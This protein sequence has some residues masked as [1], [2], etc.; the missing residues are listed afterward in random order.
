MFIFKVS[1]RLK[2]FTL[3]EGKKN[4]SERLILCNKIYGTR[5]QLDLFLIDHKI[6]LLTR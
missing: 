3:I 2:I 5:F 6:D 4:K 1:G